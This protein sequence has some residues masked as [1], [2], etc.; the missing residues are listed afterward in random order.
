ME[1]PS[2]DFP[3]P[4]EPKPIS[5]KV[6]RYLCA[7][8]KPQRLR[9]REGD[10]ASEAAEEGRARQ[11]VDTWRVNENRGRCGGEM[12]YCLRLAQPLRVQIDVSAIPT[13]IIIKSRLRIQ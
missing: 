10:D 11:T 2:I 7:A 12:S 13:T 4:S 3:P 9:G 1:Q 8:E 5:D 6:E